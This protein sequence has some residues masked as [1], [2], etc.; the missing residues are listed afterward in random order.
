M[1]L[2]VMPSVSDAFVMLL[3]NVTVVLIESGFT[4]TLATPSRSDMV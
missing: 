3:L 2:V 4:L 1:L